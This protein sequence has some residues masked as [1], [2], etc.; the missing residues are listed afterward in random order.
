MI[1][2]AAVLGA[3]GGALLVRSHVAACSCADYEWH[4]QLAHTNEPDED[5]WAKKATLVISD[6]SNMSIVS[7]AQ[8]DS[9]VDI[10]QGR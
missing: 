6:S 4:L 2:L 8:R 9:Q 3:G 10:L 7:S 5:I 1:A